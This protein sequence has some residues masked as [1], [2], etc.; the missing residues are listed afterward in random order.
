MER[1][2]KI[3]SSIFEY[4][5]ESII[6]TDELGQIIMCNPK[7][8]A[9]FGYPN[10]EEL[11]GSKIEILIPKRFEK[12]HLSYRDNFIKKPEFRSMG[13]GRN[14]FGLKKNGEEFPVE[15]SLSYFVEDSK[16]FVMCF[17]LDDTIRQ[18]QERK[19]LETN[20]ELHQVNNK[21]NEINS[22]LEL[23]V[24][25]RTEELEIAIGKLA[26]S[27]KGL[28]QALEKEK[29]LNE[30]KSRFI[31]TASHEFRTPLGTILSSASLASK[32][33]DA[34]IEKRNKHLFRIKK[35]VNNLTQILNDFLS[36]EKLDEG[37]IKNN[38]SE[39][40]LKEF[41]SEIIE[42]MN[43]FL[44]N[45]QRIV[46]NL[47]SVEYVFMD[48]FLLKNS[49][50]NL[51]SN[52]I[53]YSN[54]NTTINFDIYTNDT[55]LVF[56]VKDEGIGIDKEEQKLLFDRFFR[57][58]NATNIQGTGLGL[59]IVKRYTEIMNGRL[60]YESELNKGTIFKQIFPK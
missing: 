23:R 13:A 22:E 6:I 10:M 7:T 31:T 44:K 47:N 19:I 16:L 33:S 5:T 39:I 59:A 38:P 52:A 30:L 35:S 17:V 41:A 20:N 57:A 9:M 53:K 12:K 48:S 3:F 21:I 50:L 54:E 26:D 24:K 58:K 27:Q 28:L 4:A 45:N 32:Y 8:M 55:E 49:L 37:M 40:N 1:N 46:L 42:E 15:V 36:I 11:V 25:E 56:S 51:L 18:E 14:L 29:K 60:E 43:S 2:Q 34:D